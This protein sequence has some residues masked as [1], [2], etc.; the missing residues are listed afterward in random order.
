MP[1]Y[2]LRLW[3]GEHQYFGA[4]PST[5]QKIQGSRKSNSITLE[6]GVVQDAAFADWAA[7]VVVS[8]ASPR[9]G[10]HSGATQKFP[11]RSKFDSIPLERGVVHDAGFASWAA[12]VG[13]RGASPLGS[14]VP[15]FDK[16]IHLEFYDGS[17]QLLVRYRICRGCVAEFPVVPPGG[18]LLHNLHCRNGKTVAETLADIFEESLS[19]LRKR[20]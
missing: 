18:V 7:S 15:H 11:G 9:S 4:G 19:R 10:D 8:A 5:P 6:R 12:G 20:S 1:D 3:D 2:R 17:G 13:G 16:D 14:E